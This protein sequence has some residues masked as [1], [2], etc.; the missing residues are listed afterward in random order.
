L[1]KLIGDSIPKEVFAKIRQ[2]QK[3]NSEVILLLST[4]WE[5][6]PHVSLLSFLDI[7]V[8]SPRRIVFAIGKTSSTMS[9]LIRTRKGTLVLWAGSKH[10]IFYLTGKIS[11]VSSKIKKRTE[12][13][14]VGGLLIRI[15]RVSQDN[16]SEAPLKTTLTFDNS[17]IGADQRELN[18]ELLAIAGRF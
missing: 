5:G 15:Q 7:S 6:Y 3:S 8:V 11:K 1:A 16:S 13:F 12:G 18:K 14:E 9:N 2:Q 4:D 17:K 10:G